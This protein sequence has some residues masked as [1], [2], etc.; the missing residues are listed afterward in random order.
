MS[1]E[2]KNYYEAKGRYEIFCSKLFYNQIH[3]IK[4]IMRASSFK[5]PKAHHGEI[6]RP[7]IDKVYKDYLKISKYN[8]I[9]EEIIKV[10]EIG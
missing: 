2:T 10:E 1:L 4:E 6:N 7:N 9:T 8:G 5:S 3:N